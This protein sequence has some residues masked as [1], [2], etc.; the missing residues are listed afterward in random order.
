MQ[1]TRETATTTGIDS[2][3]PAKLADAP[4]LA[5]LYRAAY[6]TNVELGFPSRAA[7]ADRAA[8]ENWVREA[9]LYLAVRAG[10][11]LG[12]IRYRNEGRYD[13]EAPEFG[14][15]AVP[16]RARGAGVGSA[17]V[18]HAEE[19]ARREGAD[20]LRLRTFDGH[21]FL[22]AMYRR[23]GYEDVRVRRLETAPFDV[24]H[25]EKRL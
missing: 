13:E 3:R 7:E 24:L 1:S 25:M 17:L 8:L 21:P 10:K 9:R 19:V 15:L 11:L 23:R 5:R 14:R 20:R 6:A 2:I 4:T 16:P 12:S 18:G 22:P